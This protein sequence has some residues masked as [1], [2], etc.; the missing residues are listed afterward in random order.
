MADLKK[1]LDEYLL[2]KNDT[3]KSFK[4]QMPS[5]P[6]PKFTSWFQRDQPEELPTNNWFQETQHECCPSMV[7]CGNDLN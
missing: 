2:L 5:I 7:C 3:K 6:K 4:L 1:D